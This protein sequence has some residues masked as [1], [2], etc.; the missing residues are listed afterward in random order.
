MAKITKF[1]K[2]LYKEV[3][4]N[5]PELCKTLK[6]IYKKHGIALNIEKQE[7]AE[8]EKIVLNSPELQ[9]M[10]LD[11]V[12]LRPHLSQKQAKN[13]RE[14]MAN[15]IYDILNDNEKN[16]FDIV[17]ISMYIPKINL[18]LLPPPNIDSDNSDEKGTK[19]NIE[20]LL[21]LIQDEDEAADVLARIWEEKLNRMKTPAEA[22][23][24]LNKLKNDK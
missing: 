10:L 9:K 21:Y 23:E 18:G 12:R 22:K 2:R 20:Q 3:E 11:Y 8:L 6:D 7:I 14:V 17:D 1:E 24:F 4:K 15:K 13:V 16:Y 5:A 19:K